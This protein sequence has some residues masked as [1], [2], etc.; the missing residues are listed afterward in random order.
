MK[1]FIN[2]FKEFIAKG[3]VLDM[4]VAVV[5]GGAFNAIITSLVQD[6]IMPLV[7]LLTGRVSVSDWKWVIA[8]ADEAKGTAESVLHYGNFI[9]MIINFL[10]VAFSIFVALKVVLAFKEKFE[11]KEEEIEEETP[12]GPTEAELLT[13][14]RDLLKNK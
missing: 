12:A 3:N 2:E 8:K 5:I 13:E 14:I 10:I 9:Q 4:A 11:K 6:I 7:T 1:K